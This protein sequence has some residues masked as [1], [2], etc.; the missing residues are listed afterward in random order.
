VAEHRS[1]GTPFDIVVEGETPGDD[2]AQAADRVGPW[3][4]AGATW[5]NEALW[6]AMDD[7]D[8][9]RRRIAQGPPR[10]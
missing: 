6:G 7:L 2:A 1:A 8:R 4:Q 10:G 3:A 5:W 9:V